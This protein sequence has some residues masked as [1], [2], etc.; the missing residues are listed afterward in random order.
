MTVLHIPYDKPFLVISNFFFAKLKELF[1]KI[2]EIT[3]FFFPVGGGGNFPLCLTPL[4]NDAT[5]IH[6]AT[7]QRGYTE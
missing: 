5:G 7:L 3:V 6:V 1:L 2:Y 4:P